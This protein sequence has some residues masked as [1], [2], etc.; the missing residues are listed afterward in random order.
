MSGRDVGF[1]RK[2]SEGTAL[3]GS[4]P[5]PAKTAFSGRVVRLGL[6]TALVLGPWLDLANPGSR[7]C[8]RGLASPW[9]TTLLQGYESLGILGA[10]G[11]KR[12]CKAVVTVIRVASCAAKQFAVGRVTFLDGSGFGA[13]GAPQPLKLTAVAY[14]R[15]AEARMRWSWPD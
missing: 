13:V 1:G 15:R 10:A 11:F 9:A 3:L 14:C 8:A 7:A 4:T 6:P 12:A 2:M 5:C